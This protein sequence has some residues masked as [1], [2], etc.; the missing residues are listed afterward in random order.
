VYVLFAGDSTI[1]LTEQAA[2]KLYHWLA[3]V[4]LGCTSASTAAGGA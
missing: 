2:V 3:D 4:L 1:D